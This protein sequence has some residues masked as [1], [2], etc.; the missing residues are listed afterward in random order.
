MRKDW[1]MAN[2]MG[3]Y[4]GDVAS[5]ERKAWTVRQRALPVLPDGV[6]ARH[7]ERGIPLI[8]AWREYLGLTQADLAD[9]LGVTQS[10]IAQWESPDAYP[11]RATRAKIA[12]ALGI[13]VSKLDR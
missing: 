8:R 2:S 6:A 5:T 4:V 13:H 3:I 12:K 11:R 1:T 10:A 9:R 7:L